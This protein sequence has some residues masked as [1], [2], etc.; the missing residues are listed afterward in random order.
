MIHVVNAETAT[1]TAESLHAVAD[2]NYAQAELAQSD[3]DR[4]ANIER[5]DYLNRCVDRHNMQANILRKEA[6]ALEKAERAGLD[7]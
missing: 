7:A 3:T 4:T 5:R 1:V 2:W 6:F